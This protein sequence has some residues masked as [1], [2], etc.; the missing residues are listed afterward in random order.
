MLMAVT[1]SLRWISG[2]YRG[3]VNGFENQVWL[4]WFSVAIASA[5]FVLVLPWIIFANGSS[6]SFFAFQSVVA[7]VEVLVLVW[8]TYRLIP[9]KDPDQRTPWD[10]KPFR[11]LMGFS[12]TIAFTSLVWV[13]VTQ[14]DKLVLS[15]ILPLTEYSY[16]SLAVLMAS[17]VG[18]ICGPIGNAL[19][20]RLTRLHAMGDNEALIQLYRNATQL[21]VA[22]AFP[23]SLVL[24][25]FSERILWVWTGSPLIAGKAA[26][27]LTLYALG[28]GCLA[29]CT[30]PYY[31][32]F[33][34]GDLKLHLIGNAIL[35][36]LMVPALVWATWR[37]GMEGAGYVWLGS[38][39]GYFLIWV[40]LIHRRLARGLHLQWLLRDIGVVAVSTAAGAALLHMFYRWPQGRELVA[41][42]IC[43]IGAAIFC[44]AVA[45][46]SW[47]RGSLRQF[48]MPVKE[49]R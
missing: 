15:R 32:Q 14:T 2:L 39:A 8:K 37:H 36:P 43:L 38:M 21:M 41:L 33:A 16:F 24:A 18:V 3:A 7:L 22:V 49:G 45:S 27:V 4:C 48:R 30:L 11:G 5:R 31:L 1:I 28:N 46:S 10:W 44:V 13:L 19:L 42:S 29:L 34:K 26:L 6:A 25:F 20:P 12:I 35:V 9:G 17:G 23:A 47:F 40:P